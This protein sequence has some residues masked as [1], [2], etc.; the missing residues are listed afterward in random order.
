MF[1]LIVGHNVRMRVVEDRF[2][3]STKIFARHFKEVGISL[4][5]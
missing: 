4:C 5:R 1:L 2:Q 3:L